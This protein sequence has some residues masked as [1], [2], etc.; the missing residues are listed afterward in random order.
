MSENK[1]RVWDV[2]INEP[3]KEISDAIVYKELH[4][5]ALKA[6]SVKVVDYKSY[7]KA[8]DA[9]RWITNWGDV[10]DTHARKANDVLKEL[11]ETVEGEG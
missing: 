2:I 11:G 4:H 6:L 3:D 1:P 8:I 5:P 7:Q 9:L 10:H